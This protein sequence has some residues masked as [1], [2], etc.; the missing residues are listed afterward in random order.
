MKTF[1]SESQII[2]LHYKELDFLHKFN[3]S[4]IHDIS[5]C[6]SS[7]MLVICMF[8]F[9]GK[10]VAL[11]SK[12]NISNKLYF[13]RVDTVLENYLKNIKKQC[14]ILFEDEQ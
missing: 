13:H 10:D 3:C 14:N 6:E 5:D 4:A 7:S 2:K 8:E 12:V 1:H 9:R 11:R